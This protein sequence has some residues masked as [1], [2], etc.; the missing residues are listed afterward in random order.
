[1][2]GVIVDLGNFDWSKCRSGSIRSTAGKV[3][4]DLA[5]LAVARK[6]VL[7]NTGCCL[8]PFNAHL[9]SIGL[10][11]LALRMERHCSNALALAEYLRKN[12]SG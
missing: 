3:R 8:A 9:H 5:F 10:E 11:I 6:E 4:S 7:Q 2:G 12:V 1:M